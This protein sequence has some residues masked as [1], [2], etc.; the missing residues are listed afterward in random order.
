ML[1]SNLFKNAPDIDIEMIST[2]SRMPMKNAIFFCVSGIMY[3]GHNFIEE[4]VSNGAK[5]IVYS[6]EIDKTCKAIY[7]KV[8]DVSDT[9]SKVANIFYNYPSKNLSIYTISGTYGRSSVAKIINHCINKHLNCAYIGV[10]GIFYKDHEMPMS[11]P[12]LSALDNIK[13]ID[14]LRNEGINSIT[15]EATASALNLK[16]L[17]PVKPDV[18]VFTGCDERSSEYG[19]SNHDYYNWIRRYLYTLEDN[20]KIIINSDDK[21]VSELKESVISYVSCGF[22]ESST[23]RISNVSL[24]FDGICFDLT[25]DEKTYHVKNKLQGL[26]NV[27]NTAFAICCLHQ[28]GYNIQE[29]I[30]NLIDV[31]YVDGVYQKVDD[32][33]NVI[34]DSAYD[35]CSIEFILEYAKKVSKGKVVT[36]MAIN[37][38]DTDSRVK[39]LINILEKHSDVVLL[40]ED[41]SKE[42]DIM[43]IL[44]RADEFS[45]TGKIVKVAYRGIAIENGVE[46][47]NDNDTFLILG[48]GNEKFLFLGQ[49]KER[50]PS[51]AF[52]AKKHLK[53][54]KDYENEII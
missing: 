22:S 2:D 43:D 41:E 45:T 53:V 6:D 19:S 13:T 40:T 3:D 14:L 17:D 42:E 12:T 9:L 27:Y 26:S 34:V 30:D 33:Y 4:A 10:L 52:I 1:L 23:Y 11:Y 20:T 31:D 29:V 35:L 28:S 8:K 47:L 24:S 16:K 18:F 37:Y 49:G 44:S 48:K 5:A 51:D 50:Y 39:K 54:R 32:K 25:Y 21:S 7:I 15:L 38:N 36:L 46:I